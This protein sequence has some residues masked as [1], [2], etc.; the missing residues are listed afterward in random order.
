M[1]FLR[2]PNQYIGLEKVPRPTPVIAKSFT[3]YPIVI[4][5][6]D[7]EDPQKVFDHEPMRY[8]SQVGTITPE[9]KRVVITDTVRS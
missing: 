3:N 9:D 4:L 7:S 5:P 2:R 6:V 1:R 8:S